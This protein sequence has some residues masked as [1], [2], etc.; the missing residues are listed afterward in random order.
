MNKL[1][2]LPTFYGGVEKLAELIANSNAGL[3]GAN[4]VFAEQKSTLLVER[5]ILSKVKGAFN[6]NVYS[7]TKYLTERSKLKCLSKEGASMLTRKLVLENADKLTLL[8]ANKLKNIA[9]TIYELIAQLKSA[10]IT[11]EMLY[12]AVEQENGLLGE[13]LKDIALIFNL[14]EQKLAENGLLDEN[15]YLDTM[16]SIIEA[17]DGISGANVYLV[18]YSSFTKQ[19]R[20]IILSL[21]KKACNVTAILVGGKNDCVYTNETVEYFKDIVNKAGDKLEVVDLTDSLSA[22]RKVITDYLFNPT[23]FT[24]SPVQ[25]DNVFMYEA[26]SLEEE[27][28]FVAQVIKRDIIEKNKRYSDFT[29]ACDLTKYSHLI[30]DVF[31]KYEIPFFL[32]EKINLSSHT[33]SKFI[34]SFIDVYRKGYA[35]NDYLAF[36]KNPLAV[37]DS[38]VSDAFENYLL[39][40]AITRKGLTKP[41][42]LGDYKDF[43]PIRKKAEGCFALLKRKNSAKNFAFAIKNLL[44]VFGVEETLIL[45]AKE[46]KEVGEEVYA[47]VTEQAF[48]KTVT[49]LE[50]IERLLGDTVMD[51]DEFLSVMQ[52]GFT[53]CEVSVL[54]QFYDAVFVGGHKECRQAQAKYVFAVGL[55][56]DVPM[57]KSD[58]ALINDGDIDRLNEFKI[59][60]EPKIKI[61]NRREKE[62]IALSLTAFSERLYLSYSVTGIDG[63]PTKKSEIFGYISAMFKHDGANLKPINKYLINAENSKYPKKVKDRISALDYLTVK[64]GNFSFSEALADFVDG[65]T[66]DLILPSSYYHALN[67]EERAKLDDILSSANKSFTVRLEQNG[68]IVLSRGE[69]SPTTIEG[70]QECPYK[71]FVQKGLNLAERQEGEIRALEIGNFIHAVLE[72]FCRRA[73]GVSDRQS[74]DALVDQLVSEVIVKEEYE[75]WLLKASNENLY[76]RLVVECKKACYSVF[77]QY[78]NSQFKFFK[79]EATFGEKGDFP[80][81][82]LKTK[83]GDVTLKGKIDRVDKFGDYIRI[84]DYKTGEYDAGNTALYTGNKLQLYLYM[85]AISSKFTP[86][87]GY[88]SSI[89]DD[90]DDNCTPLDGNTLNLPEV[91]KASDYRLSDEEK[92]KKKAKE[93]AVKKGETTDSDSEKQGETED[94]GKIVI[95]DRKKLSQGDFTAFIDYAE[96]IATL[97]TEMIFDGVIKP[98]PYDGSCTYCQYKAFCGFR[99]GENGSPRKVNGRLASSVIVDALKGDEDDT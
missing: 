17:D 22:E 79:S 65:A 16:P 87:G 80:A 88:Y 40:Y 83:R 9:P 61:V 96:K 60:I 84:V 52:S 32:D 33:I 29:V 67:G 86:V 91:I 54:P 76:K 66:D 43:E 11:P 74:C 34:V 51:I 3:D 19:A 58:V 23:A 81:I 77:L 69:I 99:D 68:D 31:A 46:L 47:S 27:I 56:S 75:L 42:T 39:K 26:F 4:V 8:K 24:L 7:F 59:L 5:S 36:I 72:E 48:E 70:F 45:T 28:S 97:G 2:V 25:T 13:K 35:V 10:K 63:K 89:N 93:Q 64:K 55:T 44:E 41:F 62:N 82:K 92:A 15:A 94:N 71:N 38:T 53:A 30:K 6:L 73:L 85:K 14:Y 37:T 57:L 90:Y 21:C 1:Y 78:K 98:T 49:V 20:N 95:S 18:G 50:Q 12:S